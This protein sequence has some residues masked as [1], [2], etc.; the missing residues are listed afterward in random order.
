[1]VLK[2]ERAEKSGHIQ[3][4]CVYVEVADRDGNFSHSDAFVADGNLPISSKGNLTYPATDDRPTANS[5]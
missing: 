3:E 5:R 1:M 2:L 4:R